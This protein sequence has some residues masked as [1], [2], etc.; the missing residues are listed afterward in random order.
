MTPKELL[1]E[2]D[3]LQSQIDAHGKLSSEILNKI[4]YKFRLDWNYHSNAIEGNS[5]TKE[6]TRSVMVNNITVDGK[7]IKDVLEM[8]G[9][10]QVVLDLL[11]IGKGEL[12]LSEKRI[13]EVHKVIIH[14]DDIEQQKK[15][16]KWKTVNNYLY[17]YKNERFN[18]TPH[19]EVPEEMH[20][21]INWLNTQI[22]WLQN[23]KNTALHP[24]LIAFQFHLK[25]VSI[26]PFHDGNGRT[27]RIFTNLILISFGYPPIIN[28]LNEKTAY[29]QY[30]ADIQGYGGEPDLYFAFMCKK[31]LHSQTLV[32]NAIEGKDIDE[33]NDLDKKIALLKKQFDAIDPNNEVKEIFNPKLF[34]KIYDNWLSELIKKIVPIIQKFNPFFIRMQHR[35]SATNLNMIHLFVNETSDSIINETRQKLEQDNNKLNNNFEFSINADY[36]SF[37]KG[38]VNAFDCL[39]SI[40]IKFEQLKYIIEYEAFNQPG[41]KIIIPFTEKLLHQALSE[42]EINF[43]AKQLG[44]TIYQHIEFNSKNNK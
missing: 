16:G 13:Q 25:Y 31:L 30:L 43:L 28:K 1:H 23:K 15:I 14:E 36:I 4:N 41:G 32:L 7:P 38:G 21:L 10:D 24:A 44:E 33:P 2:I 19:D 26:H 22:D 17:N 27:A 42:T 40:R 34:F 3:T 9:H 11:K 39:Y 29:G 12:K 5:L 6:E 18:F 37:T 20:K 35:I 8:K